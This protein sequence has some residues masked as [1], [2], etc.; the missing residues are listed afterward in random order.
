[1]SCEYCEQHVDMMRVASTGC[2]V[3][4]ICIET[5]CCFNAARYFGDQFRINVELSGGYAMTLPIRFCPMCGARL[6]RGKNEL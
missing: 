4:E 6:S 3:E 2:D 1:M 5:T